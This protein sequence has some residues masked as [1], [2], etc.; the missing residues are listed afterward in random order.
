MREFK[1]ELTQQYKE[2]SLD[3]PL[4]TKNLHTFLELNAPNYK[5]D[6]SVTDEKLDDDGAPAK[7]ICPHCGKNVFSTMFGEQEDDKT[8]LDKMLDDIAAME[9]TPFGY[10]LN[11]LIDQGLTMEQTLRWFADNNFDKQNAEIGKPQ[12]QIGSADEEDN[13]G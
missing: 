12:K 7:L 9:I 5:P 10:I 4:I 11:F 1:I 8:K 13:N 3:I 6:I 2:D